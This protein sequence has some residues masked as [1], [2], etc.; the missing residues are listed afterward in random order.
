MLES[1][2]IF[3]SCASWKFSERLETFSSNSCSCLACFSASIFILQTRCLATKPRATAKRTRVGFSKTTTCKQHGVTSSWAVKKHSYAN[4][5]GMRVEQESYLFANG[6]LVSPFPPSFL[7]S[8]QCDDT[9][10]TPSFCCKNFNV[11]FF[12]VIFLG[13]KCCKKWSISRFS[14]DETA[15]NPMCQPVIFAD[16]RIERQ[17]SAF[18]GGFVFLANNLYLFKRETNSWRFVHAAVKSGQN[19]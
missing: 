9:S 13:R 16:W 18:G 17:L 5:E 8:C 11:I 2:V 14:R 3:L 6:P 1:S 12:N 15:T 19:A 10:G 4:W 7:P